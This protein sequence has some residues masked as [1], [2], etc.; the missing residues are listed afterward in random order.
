MAEQ[1]LVR[2]DSST[3]NVPT[4]GYNDGADA[5]DVILFGASEVTEALTTD[6]TGSIQL[7][8][9]PVSVAGTVFTDENNIR[10]ARNMNEDIVI[11]S[12]DNTISYYAGSI[13]PAAKTLKVYTDVNRTTVTTGTNVNV[14]YYKRTPLKVNANGELCVEGGGGG[15]VGGEVTIKNVPLDIN[16]KSSE[17]SLATRTKVPIMYKKEATIA[18]GSSATTI[19]L[20]IGDNTKDKYI[21]AII[22]YYNG[23]TADDP[24]VGFWFSQLENGVDTGWMDMLLPNKF[25]DMLQLYFGETGIKVAA[26]GT[27]RFR[28]GSSWVQNYI[29]VCAY[30]WQ[31]AD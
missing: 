28:T 29:H 10:R 3:N 6:G 23:T 30:G 20:I 13:D 5:Q 22:A 1:F 18:A 9:I 25:Q 7:S 21:T 8:H 26:N 11:K 31:Y 16:I 24:K 19:D 27:F 14:T 2:R 15:G 17:V 12:E 4:V